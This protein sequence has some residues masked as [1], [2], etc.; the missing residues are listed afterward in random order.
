MWPGNITAITLF[1]RDLTAS[2]QFYMDVFGLPIVFEDDNSCVF[3]FG[4]TIINLLI[5]T[6]AHDL[7]AFQC[8]ARTE[9]SP[10]LRPSYVTR[11]APR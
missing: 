10:S 1:V 5:E 6:A 2:K 4:N 3:D 9:G 11:C 8:G 7:I